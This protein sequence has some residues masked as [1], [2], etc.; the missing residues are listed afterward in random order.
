M[1]PGDDPTLR[2]TH[3]LR[4]P[5]TALAAVTA[6]RHDPSPAVVEGLVGL[7]ALPPSARAAAAAVEALAA[8]PGALVHGALV[9]ALDSP[10]VSV[11]FA[12]LE[13]LG[14]RQANDVEEEVARRLR[15]DPSWV[16]RRAAFHFLADR[17]APGR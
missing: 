11:R 10:H 4:H 5:D 1:R 12:A 14:R 16:L 15:T 17:P 2:R 7:L 8:R 3:A 13:G 6:L 9:E